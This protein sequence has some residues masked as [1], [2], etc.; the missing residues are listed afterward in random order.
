MF[1]TR[2]EEHPSKVRKMPAGSRWAKR[3]Q[4]QYAG[5]LLGLV[6]SFPC[7]PVPLLSFCGRILV[8]FN[9]HREE[10]A[11]MHAVPQGGPLLPAFAF[12]HSAISSNNYLAL[13]YHSFWQ[14]LPLSSSGREQ[15]FAYFSKLI[16]ISS[17]LSKPT[18][19]G[20]SLPIPSSFA[21]AC[22]KARVS[23]LCTKIIS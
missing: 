12:R 22:I 9:F 17:L 14:Q 21:L 23:S 8:K 18:L 6:S 1:N 20:L 5:R 2:V 4:K 16:T 19:L 10:R 3:L 13:L 11:V 15:Q 7:P